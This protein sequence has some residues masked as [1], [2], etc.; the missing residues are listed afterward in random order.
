MTEERRAPDLFA[1]FRAEPRKPVKLSAETGINR[2]VWDHRYPD[3]AVPEGVVVWGTSRG[4]EV[5]PGTYRVRLTVGDTTATQSFEVLADPRLETTHEQLESQ[6]DLA[7]DLYA[8]LN[9][10]Y[11]ALGKIRD[12]REQVTA[13]AGRMS[14]AGMDDGVADAA[15]ELNARLSAIEGEINQTRSRSMQDPLNFPPMLDNQ[16]IYLYGVVVGA[17]AQ[18]TAGAV[19]RY[20]ELTEE[21]DALLLALDVAFNNELAEFRVMVRRH[22][23][24]SVVVPRLIPARLRVLRGS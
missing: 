13:L 23:A 20:Q 14:S 2:F 21:L 10:A 22:D 18:P 4:P 8:M 3:V 12:V 16:I 9:S 15:R 7:M 6:F 5:V 17:D 11:G 1:D 19:E 24:P